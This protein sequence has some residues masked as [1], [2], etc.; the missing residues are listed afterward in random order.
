MFSKVDGLKLEY[1]F[2]YRNG[3]DNVYNA[4]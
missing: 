1:K 4:I 3:R 2:Q